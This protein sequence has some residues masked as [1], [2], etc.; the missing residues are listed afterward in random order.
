MD[1]L[2]LGLKEMPKVEHVLTR[3]KVLESSTTIKNTNYDNTFLPICKDS[4]KD[5]K[6]V[7]A[8]FTM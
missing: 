5:S 4:K 3:K 1:I 2:G 8:V 6:N 7:V